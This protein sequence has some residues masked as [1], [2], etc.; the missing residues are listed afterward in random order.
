MQRLST[1]RIAVATD[2]NLPFTVNGRSVSETEIALG[3]G[4]EIRFGSHRLLVSRDPETS[5]PRIDVERVEALSDA[6]ATKDEAR[7]FSLAGKMPGK[8]G[9]AWALVIAVLALFFAW[10]VWTALH[11]QGVKDRG[12]GFH[13][14]AAWS[15]GPLSLAHKNLEGNCQACHVKPFVAVRDSSCKACHAGVHDHADPRRLAVAMAAPTL[16]G[17]VRIA[18]QTAFNIP[19]G[20]CVDCHLEHEGAGR[21]EPARQ[22]FCADCHGGLTDRLPDT[23]LLNA[24]D[25]GTAHP[26]FRPLIPVNF[27][28]PD[29]IVRRT[30]LDADPKEDEGLKFPHAMHLSTTNAVAQMTRTLAGQQGWGQS[31]GCKDCH[32][33]DAAGAGFRPVDME[34]NC[35]ACH[36]LAFDRQDGVV[37]T[38]RHGDPRA[39][40]ADLRAY[41]ASNSPDRPA[42]LGRD[43]AAAAGRC[44]RPAQRIEL[45]SRGRPF[46]RARV[47]GD[48]GGLLAGR[49]VL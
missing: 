23:K 7:V 38:L 2:K 45:L 29:P 35:Q 42:L 8:R 43:G 6:S 33:A 9:A 13:A 17:R 37:R 11:S 48:R 24:G 12:T 19:Q 44:R 26:Q 10:P 16:G 39:V 36:S 5:E 47:D 32:T 18:F 25:F 27:D 15:S 28:G 21:M 41:Y 30:S 31:L 34:K 40:V 4:A 20:R 46:G 1:D 3:S 22:Q 49:R 14:D